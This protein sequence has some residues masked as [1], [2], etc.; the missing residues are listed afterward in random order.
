[1]EYSK[2]R[3]I[4][5]AIP[6]NDKNGIS[7]TIKFQRDLTIKGLSLS[8]NVKHPYSGDVSVALTGPNGKTVKVLGSGRGPGK[9]VNKKFSGE[10]FDDFVGIKS[11]GDWVI[12]VADNA[13]RDNGT[14]VDWT[15]D[16]T[17]AK[18]R[19]SEIFIEDKTDLSSVQYCHQFGA[20]ESMTADVH[21]EH[22]H[23]GGLV[24]VLTSP[25]GKAI[26]LHDR[27][28]GTANSIKKTYSASDLAAMTGEKAKGKWTMKISDTMPRDAGRLVHWKLNIK[29]AAHVT[30]AIVKAAPASTKDD[31]KK[32][33]GIG[34]K[35]EGLLNAGGIHT[36]SKLSTTEVSV[37]KGI[38][39]A[40]GPRYQMHDPGSWPRQAKLAANGEWDKLEK[41]QDELLGGK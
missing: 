9:D 36:W 22:G 8:L 32:I 35:I 33:E 7:D 17:L 39:S 41:L 25:S 11:K 37:L 26:T 4:K 23:I 14:L 10:M 40:A 28:G 31:L 1:M 21:V 3:V 27:I 16:W 19:K 29:T 6:D 38:L 30:A 15:L 5:K 2:K 13:T 20:I 18:S 34:P 24:L 12:N